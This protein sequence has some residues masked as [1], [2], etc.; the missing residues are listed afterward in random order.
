MQKSIRNSAKTAFSRMRNAIV[1][2]RRTSQLLLEG[3]NNQDNPD[4]LNRIASELNE[5]GAE[6]SYT[7]GF[8]KREAE[9]RQV[10]KFAKAGPGFVSESL[11][12]ESAVPDRA[13]ENPENLGNFSRK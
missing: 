1:R 10:E 6:P 11:G 12:I 8:I 5:L 7:Q 13:S 3:L 4:E 9:L 2:N